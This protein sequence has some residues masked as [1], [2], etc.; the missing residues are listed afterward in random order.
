[1]QISKFYETFV[2]WNERILQIHGLRV[3]PAPEK[4]ARGHQKRLDTPPPSEACT[5]IYYIW[6]LRDKETLKL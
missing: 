6:V 5:Y 3:H 4:L 1:M 2:Y